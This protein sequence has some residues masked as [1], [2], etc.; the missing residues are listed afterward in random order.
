MLVDA[1]QGWLLLPRDGGMT[2]A[3]EAVHVAFHLHPGPTADT[4]VLDGDLDL[5]AEELFAVALRHTDLLDLP[6]VRVE[7][8]A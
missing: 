2:P 5:S 7:I 6:H 3:A 1:G 4:A 8:A